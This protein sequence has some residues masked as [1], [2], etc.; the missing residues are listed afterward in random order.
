MSVRPR[1]DPRETGT[2]PRK[3][4]HFNINSMTVHD[5]NL[6]SFHINRKN[7]VLYPPGGHRTFYGLKNPYG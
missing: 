2:E 6:N 5:T 7:A 4:K 3:K 1:A